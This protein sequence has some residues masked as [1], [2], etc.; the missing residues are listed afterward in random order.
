MVDHGGHVYRR[1]I[2]QLKHFLFLPCLSLFHCFQRTVFGVGIQRGRSRSIILGDTGHS[3]SILPCLPCLVWSIHHLH[4]GSYVSRIT[5]TT[6][7][8]RRHSRNYQVDGSVAVDPNAFGIRYQPP[9]LSPVTSRTAGIQCGR[10]RP[11]I[12]PCIPYGNQRYNAIY[13]G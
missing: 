12:V 13:L 10:T 4:P 8:K 2:Y 5:L 3:H 1:C 11:V 7:F 9:R 6:G